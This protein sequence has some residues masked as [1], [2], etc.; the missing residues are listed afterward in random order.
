MVLVLEPF[1][2]FSKHELV[3]GLLFPPQTQISKLWCSCDGS[4]SSPNVKLV[5]FPFPQLTQSLCYLCLYLLSKH[6]A[7]FVFVS[8]INVKFMLFSSFFQE[9]LCCSSSHFPMMV[10]HLNCCKERHILL[11]G[12]HMSKLSQELTQTTLKESP[13]ILHTQEKSLHDKFSCTTKQKI[14][15]SS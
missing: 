15:I 14:L 9:F 5:L 11:A 7:C 10:H 6:E 12:M 1:F 3:V 8:S 2:S 13:H 4:F